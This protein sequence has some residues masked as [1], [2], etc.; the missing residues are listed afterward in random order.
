MHDKILFVF[1]SH[2]CK[3]NF[4]ASILWDLTDG[5]CKLDPKQ[6]FS[7]KKNHKSVSQKSTRLICPPDLG[8]K[9]QA[10]SR[11]KE[12]QVMPI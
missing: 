3:K 5:I 1:F 4:I 8:M 12:T 7:Q 9:A 11:K 10:K 6:K 2:F